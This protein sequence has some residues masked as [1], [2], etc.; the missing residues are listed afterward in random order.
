MEIRS[1]D[2]PSLPI[3]KQSLVLVVEVINHDKPSFTYV[4]VK[5]IPQ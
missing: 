2:I 3:K 4:L 1:I 5:L